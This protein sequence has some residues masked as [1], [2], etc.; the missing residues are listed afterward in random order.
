MNLD[1]YNAQLKPC[2][3]CKTQSAKIE[4]NENAVGVMCDCGINFVFENPKTP[5][6]EVV[7]WWNSRYAV[8]EE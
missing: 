8:D 4:R 5:L 6:K 2:F 1:T 3:D 7:E